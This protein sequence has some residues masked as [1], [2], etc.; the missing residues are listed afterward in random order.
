MLD[1]NG[2]GEID[3]IW[4]TNYSPTAPLYIYF[5]GSSTPAVHTTLGDLLDGA[6]APFVQPLV[7]YS[8]ASDTDDGIGRSGYFID[9]PMEFAKSVK[10][11]MP[12]WVGVGFYNIYYR[13]FAASTG[14]E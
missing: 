8:N 4:F 5:D 9:I 1:V 12:G 14:V 3:G 6:N 10:V 11:E 2:P 13:T 7:G